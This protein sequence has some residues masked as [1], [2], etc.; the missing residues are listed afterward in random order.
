MSVFMKKIKANKYRVKI[1]MEEFFLS[2][3]IGDFYEL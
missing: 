3:Y 1:S 2:F